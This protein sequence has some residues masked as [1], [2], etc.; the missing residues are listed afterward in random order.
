MIQVKRVY[1]TPSRE[2]GFRVLVDRLWPRGLSKE[3]A[4]VDLW[5]KDVAPSAELRT[6][7]AHD[8]DK[9]QKFQARYRDELRDKKDALGLLKRH[10]KRGILTLVYG[11][12]DE[13]HNQARVLK[14]VLERRTR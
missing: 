8:P 2:D 10:S 5:L 3:R 14:Q 1:E 9:W 11:A 13:E 4:A 6:W 12:R 7:F